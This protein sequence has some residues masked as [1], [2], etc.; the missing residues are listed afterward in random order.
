MK[1]F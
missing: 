1:S